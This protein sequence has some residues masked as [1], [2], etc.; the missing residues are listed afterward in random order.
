MKLKTSSFKKGLIISDIKRFWWVSVLYALALF[1]VMPFNHYIQHINDNNNSQWLKDSIERELLFNGGSSQVFL[2][3]VPIAIGALVFR[4]MQKNRQVSLYHSLPLTRTA[5]Y[6]NSILS[7]IILFAAPVFLNTIIMLLMNCFSSLSDIYSVALIFIWLGYT[8]LFGIMFLAMSVFVGMFTGS[9]IAQLA[10]VYILNLLPLYLSEFVRVNLRGMLYGFD[11]Y[12]NRNFYYDM[13]MFRMFN[14][15]DYESSQLV[16]TIVY[17][18]VTIALLIGGLYAFKV[19]RPETAGD[20]ITFR[21]IRPI[22]IYGFVTCATLFGGAYF[23]GIGNEKFSFAVVGYFIS[24]L[25]AYVVVQMLTNKSFKILHTYKGYLGFA[26]ALVLLILGVHFDVIGYV[27]KIPNPDEI[28]ET[29]IGYNIYW[30]E[31]KDDPDFNENNYGNSDTT[32]YKDI[33][34]IENVTKLH[35]YVLDNRNNNGNNQYIA[36]KLKNGKR[37]IRRYSIDTITHASVL[38]PI[39]ESD[40]YKENRFPILYQEAEDIKYIELNDRRAAKNPLIVS[41]KT[42]LE[43]FKTAIRKDI[44]TLD[45]KDLISSPN[46]IITITI[47]DTKNK[48]ITYALRSDY[49]NTIDWLKKEGLYDQIIIKPEDIEYITLQSMDYKYDYTFNSYVKVES[50]ESSTAIEITDKALI[51]EILE[52]P[53]DEVYKDSSS[54]YLVILKGSLNHHYYDYVV[55]F[56]DNI[57]KELQSYL[58]KIK[59]LEEK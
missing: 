12:S 56:G 31:H 22:F 44:K 40:E 7:A 8:L 16:I 17:I 35:Q 45:Y 51:K 48:N 30:F 43:G 19:R 15:D 58:D 6:F 52:Y 10:F 42:Q 50:I 46:E 26:L 59:P 11:T 3:V 41:D 34:N 24:S 49:T 33:K 36:Y 14:I 39:Y 9:S 2:L 38:A 47:I 28:E 57:S 23:L 55:T 27:N 25:I 54:S 29:Y 1:F 37:L 21:P 20:I 5:L 18:V 53:T 13:P 32:L 4:Y